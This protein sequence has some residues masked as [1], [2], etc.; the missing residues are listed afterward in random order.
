M[1]KIFL[2]TFLACFFNLGQAQNPL[3]YYKVF[4]GTLMGKPATMHWHV[5]GKKRSGYL[6]YHANNRPMTIGANE[7]DP[8]NDTL[9][10]NMMVGVQSINMNGLMRGNTFSGNA[11]IYIDEKMQSKGSFS[12][13]ETTSG[14]SPFEY[15]Y[16]ESRATLP[17]KMKDPPAYTY[18]SAAVWPKPAG[19]TALENVIKKYINDQLGNKGPVTEPGKL[20]LAEKKKAFDEWKKDNAKVTAKEAAEM[21]QSMGMDTQDEMMVVHE[22]SRYISLASFNYAYTGGA[23]GNYGTMVQTI[24]K[25]TNKL[26]L[27]NDVVNVAGL[28]ALPKILEQLVRADYNWKANVSLQDNGLLVD[29]VE[30]SENFFI[31]DGGIGFIYTPYELGSYAMGEIVLFVPNAMLK[32]YLKAGF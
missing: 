26:L 24:D 25:K 22:S 5:A 14:F 32:G 8:K 12:F 2:I 9:Y 30:P 29:K 17:L 7:A 6:Y 4:T 1:K 27:V 23:H 11:D 28:K 16:T 20:F 15:V 10:L 18:F 3:S 19:N 13:T 21:G 31:T